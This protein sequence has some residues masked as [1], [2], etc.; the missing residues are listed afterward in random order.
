MTGEFERI[1]FGGWLQGEHIEDMEKFTSNDFNTYPHLFQAIKDYGYKDIIKLCQITTL[2]AHEIAVIISEYNPTMYASIRQSLY[3]D[4]ARKFIAESHDKPIDE[5]VEVLQSY[6]DNTFIDLPLPAKDFCQIYWGELDD[7]I[8]R[9]II[10]TGLNKLD[11][12]LCGIRTKELTSI[13]A[14]PSVGKSAFTLQVAIAVAKQ[15]KKVLYFPLEMSKIQTIERM[16][17]SE[18]LNDVLD[19]QSTANQMIP[20]QRIRTGQIYEDDWKRISHISHRVD[21]IEQRGCFEIYEGINDIDTISALVKAHKPYMIVID[22][23]EQLNAKK[24]FR[25]KRERFSYMTST[26]KRLSMTENVAVWLACQVNRDANNDRP[27]LANLKESGSIEEDSDNVIL[28]HRVLEEH[29]G[30][31]VKSKASW[32]NNL[33]PVE[34]H[35]AKQRSGETGKINTKFYANGFIFKEV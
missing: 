6:L 7:R 8:E 20:Y 24:M 11:Q 15:R 2:K 12:M 9:E 18:M 1:L 30:D 10:K 32:S 5:I 26:L 22:Q 35:L 25:D 34:I 33:R 14:R 19:D 31:G 29:M 21:D 16:M 23:L 13:G 27:T 28:L 3:S 17:F 4:K